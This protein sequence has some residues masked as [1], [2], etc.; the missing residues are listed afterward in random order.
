MKFK[1]EF[2]RQAVNVSIILPLVLISEESL[3][4]AINAWDALFFGVAEKKR[5]HSRTIFES[6]ILAYFKLTRFEICN[7][8]Y[9]PQVTKQPLL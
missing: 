4:I 2:T 1:V 6:R 5:C 7:E 9:T 3:E 8:N